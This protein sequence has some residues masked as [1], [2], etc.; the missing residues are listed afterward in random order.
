MVKV[1]EGGDGLLVVQVDGGRPW[2]SLTWCFRDYSRGSC[3][4]GTNQRGIKGSKMRIVGAR[5]EEHEGWYQAFAEN[6]LGI[7][8][9]FVFL[10][11]QTDC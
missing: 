2:P 1:C 11:V 10:S 3:H 7:V 5:K 4:L 9:E 6:Q 8:S